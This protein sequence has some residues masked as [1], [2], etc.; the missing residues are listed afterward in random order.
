MIRSPLAT[1]PSAPASTAGGRFLVVSFH[2]LAPHTQPP[3]Q[4]LLLQLS[5]LGVP[6]ASLLAVPNG[7]ESIADRPFFTRWLRS[8]SE[9]GHEVCLSGLAAGPAEAIREGERILAAMG[10]PARG[11]VAPAKL[12]SPDAREVLRRYGF[13][14]TVTSRHVHLLKE[15]RRITAPNVAFSVRS[16]WRRL[17]SPLLGRLRFAAARQAPVLRISVHPDDLYEHGVRRT[18]VAL[19]R[20]GLQDREPVTYGELAGRASLQGL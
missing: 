3:C 4:E 12:L 20:E 18:L 14:Y 1:P 19:L 16:F 9:A 8:L 5:D 2:D 15:D 6:R 13:D 11:Y 17:A 7:V 10:C